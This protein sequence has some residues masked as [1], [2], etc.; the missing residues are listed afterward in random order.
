MPIKIAC[1]C[2]QGFQAP[3]NLAGKKVRCPKCGNPLSIPAANRQPS[4]GQRP[5]GATAIGSLLDDIGVESTPAGGKRCPNCNAVMAGHAIF[6]VECGLDLETKEVVEQTQA[7]R[8][9]DNDDEPKI[10]SFGNPL[11]DKA[12]RELEYNKREKR[13]SQDPR[14]WY[15]YFIGLMLC[16]VFVAV[17]A[18]ISLKLEAKKDKVASDLPE[19]GLAAF[20]G[21]FAVGIMV[22]VYPWAQ[23]TYTA[24]KKAG[25][26][27]GLLCLTLLY[28]PVCAFMFWKDLKRPFFMW[29]FGFILLAGSYGT[30]YYYTGEMPESL[31]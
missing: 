10:K 14:S 3:D 15:S 20:W 5:A 11:L 31:I 13:V 28:C 4:A 30:Y 29:V 1:Q 8:K 21:V 17:G 18:I 24:F 6:C 7:S 27:H 22:I 26:L 23:I 25:P 9:S 2:G 19:P 16:T 12:A